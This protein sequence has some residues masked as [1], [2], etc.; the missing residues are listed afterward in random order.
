MEKE[1]ADQRRQAQQ[2]LQL[3]KK[4]QDW[5]EEQGRQCTSLVTKNEQYLNDKNEL[6]VQIEAMDYLLKNVTPEEV[7]GKPLKTHPISWYIVS[8][9]P[10]FSEVEDAQ[11]FGN[12][13]PKILTN[14]TGLFGSME[15]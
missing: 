1:V 12:Y 13:H 14:V 6:Q 7:R 3:A 2:N 8:S 15:T 10:S 5:N 11:V 9:S 4:I